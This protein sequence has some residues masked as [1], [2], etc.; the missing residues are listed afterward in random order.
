MQN[1]GI[2]K[3]AA[4]VL[5]L[6]C[7]YALSFTFV[8]NKVENDAKAYAN[9]DSIKERRYLDSI[10]NQPVYPVFGHTY[11][12]VKQKDIAINV[13]I[14]PMERRMRVTYRQPTA[15]PML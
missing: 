13:R 6:L 7:L 9:G 2:I 10:S 12:Y 4:I 1:K 11:A 14:W 15:K 3:F 8:T 5:T